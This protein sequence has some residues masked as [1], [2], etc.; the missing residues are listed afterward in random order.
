MNKFNKILVLGFLATGLLTFFS[1]YAGRKT[2]PIELFSVKGDSM[3]PS[4]VNGQSLFVEKKTEACGKISKN[5]D[6]IIKKKGSAKTLLKTVFG[7]P[8]DII[9]MNPNNLILIN[10]LPLYNRSKQPIKMN[11]SQYAAILKGLTK[12]LKIP[13]GKILILGQKVYKNLHIFQNDSRTYGLI[14][15]SDVAGVVRD[16]NDQMIKI[17]RDHIP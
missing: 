3:S 16:I 13:Q 2:C 6:V 5:V 1:N 4:Y 9:T 12:D 8:N 15:I 10:G 17:E 14:Q 11:K 7:L